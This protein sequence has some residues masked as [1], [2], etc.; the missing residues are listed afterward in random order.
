MKILQLAPRFPF[1]HD[2]GGKIS[3]ANITREFAEAGHEVT[4]FAFEKEMPN[5]ETLALAE[6]FAKVHIQLH[7]TEN[8]IPRIMRSIINSKS[9]YIEKH[10]YKKV[11][12]EFYESFNNQK[13]D[14]I[15]ADHTCMAPLALLAK[16]FMHSPVGLRLHNVE[17]LIWQRYNDSLN[18][19]SGK[20]FFIEH[21]AYYLKQ[22]E[23]LLIKNCD[24][25]FAITK[26]DK[27]RALELA[28][29]AN[30][31]VATAG[32]N[33]DEW[34]PDETIT[35]NSNELILATTYHW[36]HNVN[37]VQWFCEKVL[38]IVRKHVPDIKLK[39]I[40]K[41]PPEFLNYYKDQGVEVLGYVD[42]VQPYLNQAS[43]YIAP[44]FVGSGIRIKILEAMAMELP[45][46][47]SPV[48]AEGIFGKDE[49]GL[50]VRE[51]NVEFAKAIIDLCRNHER[52][53][54]LGKN[55][56]KF[57][58]SE[59]SWKKNIKIMLDEYSRLLS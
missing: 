23:R 28:P 10:S 14:I 12:K 40:G 42:R 49:N 47:A 20:R 44:L 38:P 51:S 7:S 35:R 9:L 57:I 21:Q 18:A 29:E 1:P 50:L 13:F 54:E 27:E 25:S 36:V 33:A 15:H 31:L 34:Q 55:A 59:F 58:L 24:A 53:V 5:K 37:A 32:V 19:F 3:I 8:T 45:V 52:R 17:W 6:K 43:I 56:R 4:L 2:D 22:A 30:V 11:Q 46:V 48:A 41:N 16:S 26:T 39:L